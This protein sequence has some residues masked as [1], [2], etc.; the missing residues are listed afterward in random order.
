VRSTSSLPRLAWRPRAGVNQIDC[1]DI[2]FDCNTAGLDVCENQCEEGVM[3]DCV[4]LAD[5]LDHNAEKGG[6]RARSLSL[7][8][9]A[10]REGF[11]LGCAALATDPGVTAR[12]RA[13]INATLD[14]ACSRG[15]LCA[16][17]HHGLAL[18]FSPPEAARGIELLSGACGRGAEDA[19]DALALLSEICERDGSE[20][21]TRPA[22]YCARL[23]AD[24]RSPWSP[25][26]WPA[27]ALPASL[28]GC[29]RVAEQVETPAGERCVS[30]ADAEKNGWRSGRGYVC[31]KD[32]SFDPGTLYCFLGHHYFVKPPRGPWDA[33]PAS[34]AASP[35]KTRFRLILSLAREAGRQ[36]FL[37]P[38]QGYLEELRV[39]E[40]EILAVGD[41]VAARLERLPGQAEKSA[42]AAVAALRTVANACERANRCERAI[43]DWSVLD[44]NRDVGLRA[45]LEREAAMREAIE[46]K[47][48]KEAAKEAC[49]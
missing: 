13:L 47:M 5:W 4:A 15:D 25:P 1:P 16:C 23:R 49:P 17:W 33:H 21:T 26:P 28:E 20:T 35:D 12:D 3:A 19:C 42:R 37:I 43:Y 34:W 27:A 40:D 9:L 32:G 31:P 18:T 46:K 8:R 29:F 41:G 44:R 2:D 22:A 10:C 38:D 6:A 45:C 36:A 48:G 7:R 24:Q 39:T 11:G 14:P 30:V